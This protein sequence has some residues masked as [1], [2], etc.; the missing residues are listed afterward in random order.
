MRR[1]WWI[2]LL[3][4]I[5]AFFGCQRRPLEYM[6]TTGLKVIV[7]VIWK[8]DVYPD[9]IK[10]TGITLFFFR[11]GEFYMQHTTSNVD[12][13]AVQLD[14]GHYQLYMITQSPEEYYKMEFDHLNNFHDAEVSVVETKSSWYKS[15]AGEEEVIDNPE[16]MAA[17]VAEEFDV[18]QDM[19]EEYQRYAYTVQKLRKELS[20]KTKATEDEIAADLDEAEEMINYYT[21]RVPINPTSVVSQYWV[22][23][24]AKNA[25]VLK[26]LRASTTGMAKSFE[27]TQNMTGPEHGTQ[28]MTQW[29][30]TM[31][32]EPFRIGHVDGKITT[33]GLP[34][35]EKPSAMRDSTLNVSALLI[36]DKTVADY[37]FNVGDKI[38]LEEA[39]KG[40]RAL[41]RLIFGSKEVPAID[42]PDVKPPDGGG[43]GFTAA[44]EDW[45]EE[46]N[47][48]IPI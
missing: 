38:K 33:F 6:A 10:P 42:L 45:D 24:Y 16:M 44:V 15:K 28:L 19:V 35:N 8:V 43:G 27:L 30:L 47:V 34:S 11:D 18:T 41:Y 22:T 1:K 7:K 23:I 32:D 14:P 9:G 31:D 25:D 48:D 46:I 40:Y 13:C 3:L 12:S 5:V 21:I 4:A 26:S 39:P 17:G 36:D 2:V 20:G 29:T 37:V